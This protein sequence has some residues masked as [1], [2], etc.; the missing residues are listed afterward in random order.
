MEYKI[1]AEGTFSERV[2][3]GWWGTT[4]KP[5]PNAKLDYIHLNIQLSD[6]SKYNELYNAINKN[7]AIKN[8]RTNSGLYIIIEQN[9]YSLSIYVNDKPINK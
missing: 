3:D 7:L 9:E 1:I 2:S 8:G 4:L 6:S 5:L